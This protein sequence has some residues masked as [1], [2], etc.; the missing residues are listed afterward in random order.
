MA[1]LKGIVMQQLRKVTWNDSDPVVIGQI[2]LK[3]SADSASIEEVR[4][5]T[6]GKTWGTAEIIPTKDYVDSIVDEVSKSIPVVGNGK[7]TVKYNNKTA[8]FT[9]NQDIDTE[10]DLNELASR[11]FVTTT[12][13]EYVK[14]ED[15]SEQLKNYAKTT[16]LNSYYTKTESDAKFA[17]KT[18]LIA[19]ADARATT[20]EELAGL[21]S[22]EATARENADKALGQRI[23][24]VSGAVATE[25]ERAEGA[26]KALGERIDGVTTDYKA[27][28][29]QAELDAIAA[30]KS[31]TD[32]R[33]AAIKTAYEDYADKAGAAAKKYTDD[34]LVDYMTEEAAGNE[35]IRL[36]GLITAEAEARE[37]A[38]N[39][40]S[41]RVKVVED[42][43]DTISNVMDFAGAVEELPTSVADYDKGDVILVTS[44]SKEYVNDGE[45]WVEF[46]VGSANEAA[47]AGLQGRMTTAE[48]EID[49]IQTT[50]NTNK[51]TWDKAGTAVQPADIAELRNTVDNH[52]SKFDDYLPKSTYDTDKPKFALKTEVNAEARERSNEDAALGRR[53]D[54]ITLASLG[55]VNEAQA[56]TIAQSKVEAY[57]YS[58]SETEQ[59]I[60]AATVDLA[61]NT[62]LEFAEERATTVAN[63]KVASVTA[64]EEA[65][66]VVNQ[67]DAK[68]PTVGLENLNMAKDLG[69]YVFKVDKFGRIIQAEEIT[70]LDGNKGE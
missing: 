19:E 56:G 65:G 40:L 64:T 12:L 15:L 44:T 58:K 39:A 63:S 21:I 20:D 3:L 24:G 41:G 36:G 57:A 16:E 51:A 46:G 7:I 54:A 32:G 1:Y 66:I 68:N 4:I 52:T 59:K 27:Y 33:E 18:E 62:A 37:A 30:A 22:S 69:F 29:D 48:G 60:G 6:I 2:A 47:I 17:T 5:G 42:W 13:D 10:I 49:A 9:V 43:K 50:V 55:G 35:S 26:E 53:I 38:D 28:A 34:Q 8:D 70:V 14:S 31:Y 25:K 11:S 67:D 61:T 45:E 23:D